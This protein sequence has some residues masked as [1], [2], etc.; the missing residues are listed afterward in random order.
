MDKAGNYSSIAT[1]PIKLDKTKPSVKVEL[2]ARNNDGTKKGKVI[3]TFENEAVKLSDSDGNN[4][5]MN[6]SSPGGVYYKESYTDGPTNIASGLAT[7]EWRVE[8]IRY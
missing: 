7:R 2:Y 8:L 3:K 5:W 6:A 1:T 4:G